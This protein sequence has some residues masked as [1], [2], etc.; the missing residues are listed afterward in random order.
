MD[1]VSEL[2]DDLYTSSNLRY[3]EPTHTVRL[4]LRCNPSAILCFKHWVA[5]QCIQDTLTQYTDPVYEN[6]LD[7]GATL[8]LNTFNLENS[9]K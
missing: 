8:S 9:P 5:S 6:K 2:E 3:P 4:K 7:C 1:T